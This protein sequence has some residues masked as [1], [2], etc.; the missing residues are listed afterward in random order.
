MAAT[1]LKEL[2]NAGDVRSHELYGELLK[3]QG[4]LTE[5]EAVFRKGIEAKDT[6]SMFRLAGMYLQ[7]QEPRHDE[8][9]ALLKDASARGHDGARLLIDYLARAA[10]LPA[11]K[12]NRY[13]VTELAEYAGSG[14]KGVAALNPA[15]LVCYK[16]SAEEW[17][18]LAESNQPTCR[19]EAVKAFGQTIDARKVN[20]YTVIQSVSGCLRDRVMKAKSIE[21]E[22]FLECNRLH[23]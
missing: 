9:M 23:Q 17:I 6:A 8:A 19:S 16:S 3:K 13:Q 7:L 22:P 18:A 1:L 12:G 5:A 11:P 14:A 10:P 15:A 20:P 4:M 21:M 2:S